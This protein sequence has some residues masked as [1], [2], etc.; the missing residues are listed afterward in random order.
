MVCARSSYYCG[1]CRL[2][3]P[4]FH[5]YPIAYQLSPDPSDEDWMIAAEFLQSY[6][7]ETIML[8]SYEP[9][10]PTM[11][12]LIDKGVTLLG[13]QEP[14]Q[15]LESGWASTIR[16]APELPIREHWEDLREGT[17]G[18]VRDVPI[19]FENINDELFS[20]GRQ[21][22]VNE[23]LNELLEGFIEPGDSSRE[24]AP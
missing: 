22:W 11:Q 15:V 2:A 4:P 18:W 9:S 6:S 14:P 13:I 8:F 1:L 17:G 20:A 19:F 12:Y 23:T 16:F 21:R 10:L 5:N 7:I 24:N 3:Y